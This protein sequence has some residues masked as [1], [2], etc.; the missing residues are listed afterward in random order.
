MFNKLNS[1]PQH[2]KDKTFYNKATEVIKSSIQSTIKLLKERK[3]FI[4]TDED[5]LYFVKL[6][7]R[8]L[9]VMK[10]NDD[11]LLNDLLSLLDEFYVTNQHLKSKR[12]DDFQFE[13]RRIKRQI[14]SDPRQ[15]LGDKDR[16]ETALRLVN[17]M[18]SSYQSSQIIELIEKHGKYYCIDPKSTFPYKISNIINY[19]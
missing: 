1:T 19:I 5:V 6:S 2:Y 7:E 8:I 10:A 17:Q 18:N 4:Y 9:D 11:S 13:N 14:L 15:N 12:L 3:I 16:L